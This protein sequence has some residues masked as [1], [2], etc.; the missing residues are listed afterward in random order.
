MSYL[1]QYQHSNILLFNF[2]R[3]DLDTPGGDFFTVTSSEP[4][5]IQRTGDVFSPEDQRRIFS[6]GATA[7]Y[8]TLT[9]H[10]FVTFGYVRLAS[11]SSLFVHGIGNKLTF[12]RVALGLAF[13]LRPGSSKL[14]R[15]CDRRHFSLGMCR[16]NRCS[17]LGIQL[18]F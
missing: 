10:N 18:W 16:G 2:H 14:C 5:T 13:F 9:W 6:E 3:P 8:I 7:F 4:V 17:P 11:A 15:I 12:Y 1:V